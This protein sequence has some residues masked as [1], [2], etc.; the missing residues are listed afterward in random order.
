MATEKFSLALPALVGRRGWPF[1]PIARSSFRILFASINR[2]IAAGDAIAEPPYALQRTTKAEAYEY[3]AKHL[4]RVDL[5]ADMPRAFKANIYPHEFSVG[6]RQRICIARVLAL[7]PKLIVADEAVSALRVSIKAQAI[8]LMVDLQESLGLSYLFISHDKAVVESVSHRVAVMYLGEIV[9][10]GPHA[11]RAS[12]PQHPCT[13][14]LMTAVPIP[15][16]ARRVFK[17][18]VPNDKIKSPV[19]PADYIPPDRLHREC[20]PGAKRNGS[21]SFMRACPIASFLP[22]FRAG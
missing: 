14:K 11:A 20:A 5:T 8:N 4:V 7:G 22:I 6:Q 13:K 21:P 17:R 10:I 3:V 15:A 19:R 16:P 2:R 18:G 9:E 1:V 12:N